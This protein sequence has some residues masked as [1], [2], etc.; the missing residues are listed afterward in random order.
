MASPS[1][2]LLARPGVHVAIVV[3]VIALAATLAS[4]FASSRTGPAAVTPMTVPVTDTVVAC[5]G[6]RS[7]EGFTESAV[8]AAT[9]PKVPGVDADAPGSGVVQTLDPKVSREKTLI[10]L[11]APGDRGDYVGRNGERDSVTGSASGSLAPGFSVTQTE[12]TVDGK[13]RGLASTQCQPTGT[14]FWFVGP[15]SGVGERAV[16]VLTNPED[17]AATVDVTVHGRRGLVDA[18]GARGISVQ[19]RTRTEVRLDEVAPG[20]NVLA[21]HVQVRVGRLSAAITETDVKGFDP[22]G[23]DW[24]PAA[25]SPTTTLVVPGIPAVNQGRVSHVRLDLVAPEE[26]AVVTL[27]VVTPE[28]SFAPEG[29]DVVDVPAAGVA[30]VDLT[31]ALREQPAAVAVTS[32]VPVTAGAR[33][34]LRDPDI[35]GDVLYLAAASPLSAPAVVP[36][37]RTT[38]DLQTR[39][40]FSAPEGGARATVTAFAQGREWDVG[41]VDVAPSTT[42]VLTIEPPRIKGKTVDSYGLVITPSGEGALYG[43]RMLDEQG[44]RG[45]LVTSFPLTTARLLAEVPE[46]YPDVGVGSTG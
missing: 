7:R 35:F 37:N 42:E 2:R 12:R 26:A 25:E 22:L 14:D 40:I 17:A 16:L 6:L 41:R 3:V 13:G 30:T 28:G 43:V 39:L 20:E 27:S 46:S 15:A 24:F 33:V 18:P 29:V 44:P 34:E 31:E 23:T 38:E 4:A 9:P 1:A 11:R 36:E 19:P 45:P 21:L 8:A 10:S 32:D 5:P